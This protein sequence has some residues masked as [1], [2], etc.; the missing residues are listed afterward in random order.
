MFKIESTIIEAKIYCLEYERY[1]MT[2]QVII[3]LDLF[4]FHYLH[5]THCMTV[6]Y[7]A[8]AQQVYQSDGCKQ[9][10]VV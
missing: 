7:Q 8:V 6:I 2:Q 5:K 4:S 10:L 1:K 3:I 9:V